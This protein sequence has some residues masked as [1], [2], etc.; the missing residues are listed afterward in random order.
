MSALLESQSWRKIEVVP[1]WLEDEE[2]IRVEVAAMGGEED[3]AALSERLLF[4]DVADS[5]RAMA[6][7]LQGMF[8]DLKP[9]KA[10]IEFGISI[11]TET[12]KA[13][14]ILV[15]GTGSCNA[16]VTLEWGSRDQP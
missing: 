11:S 14:A 4:R 1:L 9:D 5:I 10:T 15:Q 2:V 3:V 16:K 12:G 8:R 6:S 7:A 13:V